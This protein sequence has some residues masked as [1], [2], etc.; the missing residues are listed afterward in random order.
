[1][2]VCNYLL[3]VTA[4][5]LP[6]LSVVDGTSVEVAR[7]RR[8]SCTL[9]LCVF[10]APRYSA[11]SAWQLSAPAQP[12]PHIAPVGYPTSR[13]PWPLGPLLVVLHP[14]SVFP[15]PE[16]HPR[17][18]LSTRRST[19]AALSASSAFSAFFSSSHTC[20]VRARDA[21]TSLRL[22][23]QRPLNKAYPHRSRP[24]DLRPLRPPPNPDRS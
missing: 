5:S 14:G 19:P 22:L 1:M 21:H 11:F 7:R 15:P 9:V 4:L 6:P 17:R 23:P 8:F 13:M 20:I 24:S 18:Q 3:E 10:C 2:P 16:T 12:P